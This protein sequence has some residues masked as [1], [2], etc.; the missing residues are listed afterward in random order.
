MLVLF[1]ANEAWLLHPT[2]NSLSYISLSSTSESII[3]YQSI[4]RSLENPFSVS[5]LSFRYLVYC[6]WPIARYAR[7]YPALRT[8]ILSHM[9][10]FPSENQ[11]AMP[12]FPSLTAKRS[13]SNQMYKKLIILL[14]FRTSPYLR[15]TLD[16]H[17]EPP[18]QMLPRPYSLVCL[19]SNHDTSNS[20]QKTATDLDG[21][22][23]VYVGGGAWSGGRRSRART[24]GSA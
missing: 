3:V 22:C 10:T 9:V 11:S 4:I 13:L 8:N 14:P 12:N 2:N 16:S 24:R 19:Q 23:A 5:V 17:I 15:Y 20:C 6:L 1:N 18:C 7:T 21:S